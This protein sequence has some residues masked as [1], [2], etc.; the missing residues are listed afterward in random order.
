MINFHLS[1]PVDNSER[2]KI[3]AART[4]RYRWYEEQVLLEWKHQRWSDMCEV[5]I[6]VS[7]FESISACDPTERCIRIPDGS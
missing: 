3:H 1:R 2:L 6:L 5:R 7:L 4:V